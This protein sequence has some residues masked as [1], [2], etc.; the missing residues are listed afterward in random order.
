MTNILNN[1]DYP[2][3]SSP[4]PIGNSASFPLRTN[5]FTSKTKCILTESIDFVNLRREKE[6]QKCEKNIIESNVVCRFDRI[7]SL[8]TFLDF[9]R[10]VPFKSRRAKFYK[11]KKN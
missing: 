9:S 10:S 4:H 3:I 5:E 1:N 7:A 11:A 8:L 2:K 6:K